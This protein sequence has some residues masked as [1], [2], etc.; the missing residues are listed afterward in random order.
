MAKEKLV[1][2]KRSTHPRLCDYCTMCDTMWLG[3]ALQN[4]R[5]TSGICRACFLSDVAGEN[6]PSTSV[7]TGLYAALDKILMNSRTV[8]R[9]VQSATS[10]SSHH[11]RL[12]IF[13]HIFHYNNPNKKQNYTMKLLIKVLFL[14]PLVAVSLGPDHCRSYY[15]PSDFCLTDDLASAFLLILL[16]G[17][18]LE[19]ESATRK[20][21]VGL[22]SFQPKS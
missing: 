2:Q 16:T 21:T 7:S 19:R 10:Y 13:A 22:G 20:C 3:S 4:V 18:C 6:L 9:S 14:L 11:H 12:A 5:S 8:E 1:L 17:R 15:Y